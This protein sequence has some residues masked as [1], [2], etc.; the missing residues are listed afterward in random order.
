MSHVNPSHFLWQLFAFYFFVK[1]AAG[2]QLQYQ[3]V[4]IF[5]VVH[6]INLDNVGMV[7]RSHNCKL[8]KEFFM[9]S[10]LQLFLFYHFGGSNDLCMYWLDLTNDPEPSST[11]FPN[12]FIIRLIIPVFHFSKR[13]P[14]HFDLL[15]MGNAKYGLTWHQHRA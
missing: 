4:L 2:H 11:N 14:S 1:L 13:I 10:L 8:F 12:D 6:F 5:E 9:V 7:Q 15:R 3:S